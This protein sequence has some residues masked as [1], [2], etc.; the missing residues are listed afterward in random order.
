MEKNFEIEKVIVQRKRNYTSFT[1]GGYT[2]SLQDYVTAY[3][4]NVIF[5]RD[6]H[7]YS[8]KFYE[9]ATELWQHKDIYDEIRQSIYSEIYRLRT[10]EEFKKYAD[11]KHDF[12]KNYCRENGWK[13]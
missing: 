3:Y 12:I 10:Y 11:E 9:F 7:R 1:C 13:N 2:A 5:K 6:G 4:V 8:R